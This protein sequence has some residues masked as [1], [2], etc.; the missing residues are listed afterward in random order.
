[1]DFAPAI[2]LLFFLFALSL[3][4][5]IGYQAGRAAGEAKS[6]DEIEAMKA[7]FATISRTISPYIPAKT[8]PGAKR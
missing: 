5:V 1:M 4:V 6:G 2:V 3:A 7:A 8:Q